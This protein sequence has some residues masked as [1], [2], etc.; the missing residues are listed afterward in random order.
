MNAGLTVF[1]IILFIDALGL[2]L[3]LAV[4]LTR[5]YE[6]TV[7]AMVRGGDIFIGLLIIALQ[8]VGTVGL[9]YHFWEAK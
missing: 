1:V 9:A 5:G 4:Y 8:V 7:T 3:D 6:D 2:L